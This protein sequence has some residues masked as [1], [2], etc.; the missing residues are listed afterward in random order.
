[1]SWQARPLEPLASSSGASSSSGL[2]TGGQELEAA[3]EDPRLFGKD[4]PRVQQPVSHSGGLLAM[5][6]CQRRSRPSAGQRNSE[7][8][9]S[10]YQGLLEEGQ[11]LSP[12]AQ[13]AFSRMAWWSDAVDATGAEVF[14]LVPRGEDGELGGALD[15]R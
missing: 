9:H 14:M 6:S 13:Q 8:D 10:A 4:E 5:L 2:P 12:D 3:P 11:Q 7:G 15:M 1:M